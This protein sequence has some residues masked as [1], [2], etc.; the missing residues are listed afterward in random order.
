MGDEIALRQKI[1]AFIK[2][3]GLEMS[4]QADAVSLLAQGGSD[5]KFYRVQ[6][7]GR[8]LVVMSD[9]QGRDGVRTYADVGR[10]LR[11]CGIGAPEIMAVDEAAQLLLMEDLG[12]DSL[13]RL[14]T[15]PASRAEVMR[16]YEKTLAL[17][18]EMQMRATPQAAGCETLRQRTF[19]YEAFRWETDYF[20]ERFI[21]EFCALSVSKESALEAE[22]HELASA[23]SEAPRIFM[24]RDFQ[25]QNIYLKDGRV[26][27]IDFQT[28]TRGLMQYDLA[29]LLKDAYVML[30]STEREA[31]LHYYI[32]VL[33]ETWDMEID[34]VTFIRTFHL[35]GLQRNMQALGAF[36][37]LGMQK[38]K[39][40]FFRHIPAGLACLRE[41]L[42][43]FQNYPVLCRIVEEAGRAAEACRR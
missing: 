13:Y 23:L 2:G 43:R 28:A 35:A 41:G 37:F 19:G 6:A 34:D 16:G 5:R 38:G 3:A 31:L 9:P 25:S 27:V 18:A 36:A 17:L 32:R 15:R 12:D 24:H 11:T 29:S 33:R 21:G 1:D 26:R 4:A 10:F 14:L 8:A 42:C 22:L 40:E 20:L 30:D 39:T 7:D